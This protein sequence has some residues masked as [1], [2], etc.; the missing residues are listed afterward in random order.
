VTLD[1]CSLGPKTRR[2]AAA[3][4]SIEEK[5]E[6]QRGRSR[7][8][9]RPTIRRASRVPL[10]ETRQNAADPQENGDFREAAPGERAGRRANKT[11]A[12]KYFRNNVVRFQSADPAEY[13]RALAAGS[14]I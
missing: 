1:R 2:S 5:S 14:R 12:E 6:C 7:R 11:V 9:G 13:R 4:R 8:L 10:L 3:L